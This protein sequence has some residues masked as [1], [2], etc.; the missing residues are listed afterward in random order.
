MGE[1]VT[2]QV[3]DSFCSLAVAR[4]FA[5]C[6][7][8]RDHPANAAIRNQQLHTGD[9][10][11]IPDLAERIEEGAHETLHTFVRPG[12]PM[13]LVRFV[14]DRAVP[15][16]PDLRHL[17]VSNYRTDRAG[18][19]ASDA[20]A[21]PN[22][23]H[24]HAASD[25]DTDAFKIEVR[26][27]RSTQTQAEVLLE[28]LHPDYI[29]LS[30]EHTLI[31][32]NER[33]S[34]A[35]ERNRRQLNI[36]VHRSVANPGRRFRSA[37]LRLVAD[38]F[39]KAGR[40]RQTLLVTDD[41]ANED[42]VEILDQAVRATYILQGCPAAGDARCRVSAVAEVG[43]VDRK[44]RFK[45]CVGIIRQNAG[46]ATGYGGVTV[47]NVR[48]RVFRWLRRIY[49]QAN[50]A[51]KIVP[52]GIRLLDP[53]SRNMLTI[54]DVN[55]N[56]A[57]GRRSSGASPSRMS[58]TM[59]TVRSGGVAV[60]KN[61][62]LNIPRPPTLAA[63]Q[64]P[65]QIANQL[66]ALINDADFDATPYENPPCFGRPSNRRSAD[67]IIKDKLGGIVTI[68]TVRNTD[69]GATLIMTIPNMLRV[70]VRE[71]YELYVGHRQE[72]LILRTYDSDFPNQDRVDCYVIGRFQDPDLFGIACPPGHDVRPAYRP[73]SPFPFSTLL[74]PQT[75]NGTDNRAQTWAHE[76]GHILLD[77]FHVPGAHTNR[78]YELMY[79]WATNS[80]SPNTDVGMRGM[81]RL[82]DDPVHI[83]YENVRPNTTD[84]NGLY[85]YAAASRL[86]TLA[87]GNSQSIFDLW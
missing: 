85:H 37:Y 57:S 23:W 3:G 54:S 82:C 39:D 12:V 72:R 40:P 24:T 62:S 43:T 4:G 26:D 70:R 42:W 76:L 1:R 16:D 75:M 47:D 87:T 86:F 22:N 31:G 78:R 21:G 64:T 80:G 50:L 13:A 10:V 66:V 81:K 5:D 17:N 28:A 45:I 52:P 61:V 7:P 73:L 18:A 33:W 83:I 53:P 27:A 2:A 19:N 14:L 84:T 6:Q 30:G 11:Y 9:E 63:R 32:F 35:A 56:P 69:S 25:F 74:V 51:P 41:Q 65:L 60:N 49:A 29:E 20:F 34:T 36:Q 67:V 79:Q 38:E 44:R 55:G 48:R 68:S 46:D 59:A 15:T 77:C 71:S 58:F 8:L